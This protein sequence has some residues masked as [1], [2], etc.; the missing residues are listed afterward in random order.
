MSPIIGI[1]GQGIL[2]PP[3]QNEQNL[4]SYG[5]LKGKLVRFINRLVPGRGRK[6][7]RNNESIRQF[8]QERLQA[9]PLGDN[10]G[11]K[12]STLLNAYAVKDQPI[13]SRDVK[14]I[15]DAVA[16]WQ[17]ENKTQTKDATAGLGD[18][19]KQALDLVKRARQTQAKDGTAGLGKGEKPDLG[20][21]E[22]DR[23]AKM[24]L[25]QAKA[26]AAEAKSLV[27]SGKLPKDSLAAKLPEDK[28]VQYLVRKAE[29]KASAP[30]STATQNPNAWKN[31]P[32]NQ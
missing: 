8:I 11:D 10:R 24:I 21:V 27:K 32:T 29:I 31:I 30:Q 25:Q 3:R 16:S 9:E 7:Q 20:L 28:L 23:Q 15:N 18:V 4:R 6:I 2:R 5:K 17:T 26:E 13:T 19:E 14:K 12:I 22:K 1:K